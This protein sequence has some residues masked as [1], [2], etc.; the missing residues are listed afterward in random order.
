MSFSLGIKGLLE[1]EDLALEAHQKVLEMLILRIRFQLSC[2]GQAEHSL[3]QFDQIA[4]YFGVRVHVVFSD[5][6]QQEREH[7]VELDVLD[8]VRCKKVVFEEIEGASGLHRVD[9]ARQGPPQNRK[10]VAEESRLL[11]YPEVVRLEADQEAQAVRQVVQDLGLE[12][13]SQD[14]AELCQMWLGE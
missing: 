11:H 5:H 13:L 2:R 4:V 14:S 12:V 6:V 1:V 8:V 7:C 9:L 3:G 10:I